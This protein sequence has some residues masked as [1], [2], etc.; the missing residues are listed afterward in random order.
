MTRRACAA[1]D[2]AMP[3][4]AIA[5]GRFLGILPPALPR[6]SATSYPEGRIE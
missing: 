5:R 1:R 6:H 4:K 3:D 2:L